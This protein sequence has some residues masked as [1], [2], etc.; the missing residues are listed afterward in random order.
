M[1]NLGVIKGKEHFEVDESDQDALVG[2]RATLADLPGLIQGAHQVRSCPFA[3]FDLSHATAFLRPG[4]ALLPRASGSFQSTETQEED[5]DGAIFVPNYPL[6]LPMSK[7]L[8][9]EEVL[10][11]CF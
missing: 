4:A 8:C 5:L 9:R 1:P 6:G 11:G 7:Y 10:A 3:A 2:Q